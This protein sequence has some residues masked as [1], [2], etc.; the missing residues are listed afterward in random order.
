MIRQLSIDLA[1]QSS[2]GLSGAAGL[3]R[4]QGEVEFGEV[5]C[6][7]GPQHDELSYVGSVVNVLSPYVPKIINDIETTATIVAGLKLK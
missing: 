6:R 1:N 5:S 7:M 4:K 2:F 3:G